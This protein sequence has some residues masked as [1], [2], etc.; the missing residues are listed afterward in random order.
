[1]AEEEKKKRDMSKYYNTEAAKRARKKYNDA[2]TKL[3]TL[4]LNLKLD[5]DI[6][7]KLDDVGNKQGYIKDLI[8]KDIAKNQL[9]YGK[10]M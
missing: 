3:I 10:P 6:L 4:R 1:M 2:N 7:D 8:R 9:V 5:A